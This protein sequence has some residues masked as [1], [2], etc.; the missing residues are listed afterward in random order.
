MLAAPL[1]LPS[2]PQ[3]ARTPLRADSSVLASSRSATS[4]ARQRHLPLGSRAGQHCRGAHNV[5]CSSSRGE[6][7]GSNIPGSAHEGGRVTPEDQFSPAASAST[8][9][10][11]EDQGEYCIPPPPGAEG[12]TRIPHR[13]SKTD[14][15]FIN[16]CRRAYGRLAG[17]QS[18]KGWED[19]PTT[20][21]GMIEVSRA[22]MK[23]KT[24][25]QQCEAVIA[26]FP[27]I[28]E[29]FRRLFPYSSWG[30]EL[31]AAITPAFFSWLVG[32]MERVEV[33]IDG[34]KQRSGVHIQRCRY[35]AESG[36]AGMCVNLCKTPTQ[37]RPRPI[38][39]R[40]CL[41]PSML[42]TFASKFIPP[43]ELSS[44]EASL[45]YPACVSAGFLYRAAGTGS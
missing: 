29:W 17:W 19:G 14:V 4:L 3:G 16:V 25:E 32:P 2:G 11:S 34:R 24:A 15:A 42:L 18:D 44:S 1:C 38:P 8:R 26:G 7:D 28:P 9:Q 30:A 45:R 21:R 5:A 39:C 22:L 35:L 40:I 10:G 41:V 36:C 6:V 27:Q 37:A 20:Y 31:N 12:A 23:G 13:D 43:L 33:E